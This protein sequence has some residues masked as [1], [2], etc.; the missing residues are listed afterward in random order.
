MLNLERVL[1]PNMAS[2]MSAWGMLTSELRFEVSRSHV[3][4]TGSLDLQTVDNLYQ[5]CG[6]Q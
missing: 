4:D 5:Q 1:I 3:G 2:V 6:L